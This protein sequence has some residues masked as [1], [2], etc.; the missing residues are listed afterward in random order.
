[1]KVNDE[2]IVTDQD[3]IFFE[4][5]GIIKKFKKIRQYMLYTVKLYDYP[6]EMNFYNEDIKFVEELKV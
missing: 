4:R 3:S 5:K 6:Y 1:M 2:I